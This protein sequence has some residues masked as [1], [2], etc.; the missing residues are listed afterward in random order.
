[1]NSAGT[2]DGHMVTGGLSV[3]DGVDCYRIDGVEAMEPFLMTVVSD[4]DLWMF[5]SSTGALTAGRIDADHAFFPYETD[6]RLH[7]AAGNAGPVT[8][9][10]RSVDGVRETWQPY[11]RALTDGCRRS[12]AKSVQGDRLVFEEHNPRWA[13]TFRATWAP[14]DRFGWVRTVELFDA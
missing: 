13:V 7:R 3:V 1:M 9:I 8:V 14:S 12:I 5:V 10:A 4:T 6:D 2:D 11:G